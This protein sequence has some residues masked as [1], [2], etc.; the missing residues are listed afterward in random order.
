MTD[1]LWG[2]DESRIEVLK[3]SAHAIDSASRDAGNTPTAVLRQGLILG[4][5]TATGKLKQYDPDAEDGTEVPYGVLP[6]ELRMTD[7]L[8][9]AV[10]RY[11][12][13][14]VSAPVKSDRLLI[15]GDSMI[16]HDDEDVTVAA[17]KL[18]FFRLS[19]ELCGVASP[20]VIP[21]PEPET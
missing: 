5:V 12:P 10:D 3:S 1:L 8:G 15:L 21:E 16:G 4:L 20:L 11:C 7:E 19:H 6:V 18:K 14:I 17:L 13:V 2:G 9:V